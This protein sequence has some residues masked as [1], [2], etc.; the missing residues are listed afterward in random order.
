MADLY[1]RRGRWEAGVWALRMRISGFHKKLDS[2]APAIL[3]LRLFACLI[4]AKEDRSW[5]S[6]VFCLATTDLF[7][8]IDRLFD[9]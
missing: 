6:I 7:I 1:Q 8:G 4:Y 9:G 5:I 3:Q 2:R